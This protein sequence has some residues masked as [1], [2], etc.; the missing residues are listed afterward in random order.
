MLF[1]SLLF[2]RTCR[3]GNSDLKLGSIWLVVV[4]PIWGG[5]HLGTEA[6][7]RKLPRELTSRQALPNIERHTSQ[8]RAS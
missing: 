2:F 4:C 7:V 8:V 3:V 5:N 6:F 1:L